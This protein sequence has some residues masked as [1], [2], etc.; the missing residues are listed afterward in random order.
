MEDNKM[1]QK[2]HW[3]LRAMIAEA[4]L[5]G[6]ERENERLRAALNDPDHDVEIETRD[7]KLR[8]VIAEAKLAGVQRENDCLQAE[9]DNAKAE[10]AELRKE[11]DRLRAG[12]RGS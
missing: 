5:A 11:Q 12:L 6:R 7:Q 9:L 1:T 2:G 3:R 10:L 8:V 4:G